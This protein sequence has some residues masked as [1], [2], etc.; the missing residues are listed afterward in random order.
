MAEI[1][2]LSDCALSVTTDDPRASQHMAAGLRATGDWLEV[3]AGIDTVSVLFDP[4]STD[5][6]AAQIRLEHSLA[7]PASSAPER[8]PQTH[9]IPV[10]YG[11]QAGPDLGHVC[12]T[13]NLTQAEFIVLHTSAEHTVDMIGFTPGFAYISGLP[14]TLSIPRLSTPRTHVPAG[15][16]GVTTGR[17]GTYA[18]PGPGGWPLIGMT[19][20]SLFDPDRA[21]PFRLHP[22][23]I[24]RFKQA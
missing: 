3:V 22:G 6:E 8:A 11:G 5:M 10:Q 12:E 18:L 14:E 20:L 17:T 19:D 4:T 16:I 24:I 2:P 15:S 1:I 13:L 23:D 7:N 21:D 9:D